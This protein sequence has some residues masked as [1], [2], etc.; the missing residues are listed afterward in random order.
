M[1]ILR[2]VTNWDIPSHIYK[3]NDDGKLESYKKNGEG[4]WIVFKKPLFFSKS[5]R[6]FVKCPLTN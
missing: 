1:E 4:D 6:K 2:E 3:L 5:F